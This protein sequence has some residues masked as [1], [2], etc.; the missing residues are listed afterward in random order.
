MSLL[1]ALLLATAAIPGRAID[2]AEVELYG[3]SVSRT[4]APANFGFPA[5]SPDLVT[6]G[7]FE[8][9]IG[10]HGDH[11]DA[12][13]V[14]DRL[15]HD[16][17]RVN[18]SHSFGGSGTARGNIEAGHSISV[19]TGYA[20]AG[21][22]ELGGWAEA[23]VGSLGSADAAGTTSMRIEKRIT[24][25][26]GDSGLAAGELVTGLRW[27]I[28]GHGILEVG[29]R[30]YPNHSAASASVS[31]DILMLRGPTGTCGAFDCIHGALAISLDLTTSLAVTDVTPAQQG[32]PTARLIRHD[33]WT[34]SN[35]TG[36]YKAGGVFD[37]GTTEV[38]FGFPVT[39]D[40]SVGRVEAVDT[41]AD[42]LFLDA[43]E[44]E[45][46][47]G[48]TLK[49]TMDLDVYASVGGLGNGESDFFGSFDGHAEDSLGRGLVFE[50]SVPVPEPGVDTAGAFAVA[51]LAL[52]RVCAARRP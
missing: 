47:V 28:D 18:A 21:I 52:W 50:S 1:A 14:R 16:E 23:Y 51:L 25:Q 26:P 19:T 13:F 44:F 15:Y 49:V 45:A 4:G 38:E 39:Q 11:E 32:D 10:I 8:T 46:N 37:S 33:T 42:P 41:G 17:E 27:A 40:V 36:A 43:I 31:F 6:N 29:G 12:R 3:S 22:N 5:D 34:A 30:S 2:F 7:D 35:N 9:L 24:I 20:D 48:E